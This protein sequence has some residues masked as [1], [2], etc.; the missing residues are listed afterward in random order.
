MRNCRTN[1]EQSDGHLQ[2]SWEE[3][4]AA[5]RQKGKEEEKHGGVVEGGWGGADRWGV[6]RQMR[7]SG[8]GAEPKF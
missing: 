5:E 7:R 6:G 1:T 8:S 4:K 2:A 3:S